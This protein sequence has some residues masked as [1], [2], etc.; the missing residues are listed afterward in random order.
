MKLWRRMPK[1]DKMACVGAQP[2]GEK[3]E[4]AITCFVE[5]RD[6]ILPDFQRWGFGLF[7]DSVCLI[8]QSQLLFPIIFFGNSKQDCFSV[9][10]LHIFSVH[11]V[12]VAYRSNL[13]NRLIRIK[14]CSKAFRYKFPVFFLS[15]HIH[16]L[17]TKCVLSRK[18]IPVYLFCHDIVDLSNR[19]IRSVIGCQHIFFRET[20]PH[21]ILHSHIQTH[22]GRY[23][24]KHH[25]TE[26]TDISK[27]HCILLHP[28]D[29]P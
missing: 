12:I 13:H 15:R 18:P 27:S 1:R 16:V 25:R 19:I 5:K 20:I 10:Q 28:V 21:N 2:C 26:D 23:R 14:T 11:L 22:C 4:F 24:H 6:R 29:H 7:F 9:F 8:A 3:A 17:T